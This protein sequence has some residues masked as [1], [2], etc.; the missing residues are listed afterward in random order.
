MF[1]D[2]ELYIYI[3]ICICRGTD[4]F[5]DGGWKGNVFGWNGN[6]MFLD[7]MNRLWLSH[8]G[9]LERCKH[10]LYIL[11]IGQNWIGIVAAASS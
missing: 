6:L 3:Y 1:T 4:I 2:L 5:M 11:G 8:S 9:E 10:V 7:G